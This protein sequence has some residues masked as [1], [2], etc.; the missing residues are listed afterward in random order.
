MA[1]ELIAELQDWLSRYRDAPVR[2]ELF[3]ALPKGSLLID[4]VR[5]VSWAYEPDSDEVYFALSPTSFDDDDCVA[6]VITAK[7]SETPAPE[8]REPSETHLDIPRSA[9]QPNE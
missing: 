1:S 4:E 3:N 7:D 8:Q 9:Y 2:I 5:S 6:V